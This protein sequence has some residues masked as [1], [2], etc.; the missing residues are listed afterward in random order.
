MPAVATDRCLKRI[1][2]ALDMACTD[3]WVH[4]ELPPAPVL[5]ADPEVIQTI[6][7]L[8]DR[9]AQ[10]GAQVRCE[11]SNKWEGLA[12]NRIAVGVSHNDQKDL[13]RAHLD[14]A[15]Y[16]GVTVETANF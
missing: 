7:S 14:A 13:L 12:P 4:V 9:L 5:A 11:I 1:D 6:S 10:R 8:V 2:K 16:V 3:A 15:G